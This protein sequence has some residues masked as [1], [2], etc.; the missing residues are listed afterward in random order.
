MKRPNRAAFGPPESGVLLVCLLMASPSLR[1]QMYF[2]KD[3]EQVFVASR[4]TESF[5]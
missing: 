3:S 2:T 5:S 1:V 4:I